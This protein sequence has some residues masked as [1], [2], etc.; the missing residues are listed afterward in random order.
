MKYIYLSKTWSF[1]AALGAFLEQAAELLPDPCTIKAH[2]GSVDSFASATY[3]GVNKPLVEL[4]LSALVDGRAQR[5]VVLQLRGG[6]ITQ[7]MELL[8]FG[9]GGVEPYGFN[10]PVAMVSGYL[11]HRTMADNQE[12][13][14]ELRPGIA[15]EIPAMA[16][17]LA[18]DL[19]AYLTEGVMPSAETE[20]PC[21]KQ[22]FTYEQVYRNPNT[23]ITA[24]QD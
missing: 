15:A 8:Y 2:L 5:T 1:V 21:H 22:G 4:R 11:R 18:H 24:T 20:L 23:P 16:Q 10:P 6:L 14:M 19:L 13:D 3:R 17:A 12:S 7:G 9:A